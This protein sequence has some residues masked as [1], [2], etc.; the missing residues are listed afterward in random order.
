MSTR[1]RLLLVLATLA[2]TLGLVAPA[3]AASASSVSPSQYRIFDLSYQ[4]YPAKTSSYYFYANSTPWLRK[5]KWKNW[6]SRR[7][8]ATGRYVLD[9]GTCG[10]TREVYRARVILRGR[11]KCTGYYKH[12]RAYNWMKV[13]VYYPESEGGTRSASREVGCPPADYDPDGF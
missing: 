5:M 4:P 10:P 13:I 11:E 6:G 9:C 7:A 2:A 12:L 8:V 3:S 1:A